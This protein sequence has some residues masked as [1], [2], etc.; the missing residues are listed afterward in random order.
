MTDKT[1]ETCA[2]WDRIGRYAEGQC[3]KNAPTADVPNGGGAVWPH[4]FDDDWCFEWVPKTPE[5][6]EC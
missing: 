1:C 6:G 3:R 5:P 4:S 2:A